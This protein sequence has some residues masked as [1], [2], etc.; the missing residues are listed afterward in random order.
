ML[1]L[2][3]DKMLVGLYL[4]NGFRYCSLDLSPLQLIRFSLS[5]KNISHMFLFIQNWY[6]VN[7][8]QNTTLRLTRIF[9]TKISKQVVVVVMGKKKKKKT[10]C[11]KRLNT[12]NIIKPDYKIKILINLNKGVKEN[13]FQHSLLGCEHCVFTEI[14][15]TQCIHEC[16]LHS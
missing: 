12:Q 8:T 11:S 16:G 13:S 14:I 9:P 5:L 3:G 6:L 4:L 10:I 2:R 7:S 1:R 15:N